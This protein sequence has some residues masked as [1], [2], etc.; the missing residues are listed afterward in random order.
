[1]DRQYKRKEVPLSQ[2]QILAEAQSTF[3]DKRKNQSQPAHL[4]PAMNGLKSSRKELGCP[5]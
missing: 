4:K 3:N 2:F 1:M 5:I